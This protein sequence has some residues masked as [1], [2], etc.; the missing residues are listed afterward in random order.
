[1]ASKV[2]PSFLT[3]RTILSARNDDGS[4]INLVVF[5]VFPGDKIVYFIVDKMSKYE[6]NDCS[7]TNRYPT[8]YLN[9]LDPPRLPPFKLEIKVGSPIMLLRNLAPKEGQ[10]NGTRMMVIRCAQ[11]ITEA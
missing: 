3:V 9:S 7:I 5:N 10:C 8:E 4:A 1:M 11:R 2:S 6:E